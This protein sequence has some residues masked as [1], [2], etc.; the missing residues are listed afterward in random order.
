MKNIFYP[1]LIV[2]VSSP[3][4]KHR[5]ENVIKELFKD[6]PSFEWGDA[7]KEPDLIFI[8]HFNP[9]KVV[10]EIYDDPRVLTRLISNVFIT[11]EYV[12]N[13]SDIIDHWKTFANS[14]PESLICV[15]S[16]PKCL[17]EEIA[18]ALIAQGAKV[19]PR[20]HEATH[21][22]HSCQAYK[23]FAISI[24]PSEL[25]PVPMVQIE[26]SIPLVVCKALFKIREALWLIARKEGREKH[27]EACPACGE[28]VKQFQINDSETEVLSGGCGCG[29]LDIGASPGGWSFFLATLGL[30]VRAVDPGDVHFGGGNA[31]CAKLKFKKKMFLD[32]NNILRLKG[33]PHVRLTHELEN[34]WLVANE[35]DCN[36][37]K[38]AAASVKKWSPNVTHFPLR[39][40]DSIKPMFELSSKPIS[41]MV[42]D[43]NLDPRLCVNILLGL[44]STSAMKSQGLDFM[45]EMPN[46]IKRI[47]CSHALCT[48]RVSGGVICP[49]AALVFTL[50]ET[51]PGLQSVYVKQCKEL[52][53]TAFDI[54]EVCQLLSN[55]L[56]TTLVA[57]R[58]IIPDG[59]DGLE[60]Q[61]TID[62]AMNKAL[63]IM[64]DAYDKHMPKY[65]ENGFSLES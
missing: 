13:I 15:R 46:N 53:S 62:S 64:K 59:D 12:K 9:D 32:E 14:H 55:G 39:I 48:C 21:T 47:G 56:E 41:V 11:D 28:S 52:L 26:N 16:H 61:F 36:P 20:I 23:R 42:C 17:T 43:M 49:H 38:C 51:S 8:R 50:K 6:D 57:R 22:L 30:E 58:K 34:E 37:F 10:S 63:S 45:P 65:K 31:E 27:W 29:A 4:H 5:L 54:I 2:K 3:K 33:L 7:A 40:Q 44:T 35:C 1:N 24:S 19:T 60:E 25:A 18:L